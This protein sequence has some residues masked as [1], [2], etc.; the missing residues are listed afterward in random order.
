MTAPLWVTDLAAAFWEAANGPEPFPRALLEPVGRSGFNLTVEALTGLSLRKVEQWVATLGMPLP[1][2][3][4]DRPL[5]ACLVARSGGGFIFLEAADSAEERTFSLAHE[6]AHFLRDYWQRRRRAVAVFGDAILGVF[7]GHRPARAEERLHALLRGVP[8]GLHVHLMT[9]DH[10][11]SPTAVARA[12]D[13][14][15]RLAWEL[16]A[17]EADV[18]R[19]L[20][21]RPRAG[22]A[23]ALLQ[24]TFGL[25]LPAAVDYAAELFPPAPPPD[26]LAARLKKAWTARRTGAGSAEQRLGGSGDEQRR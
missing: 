11:R 22:A 7:D 17:P 24:R 5:R 14:A 18:R 25:P 2:G 6:L 8:V 26:P 9:R 20:P 13:A 16:L 10:G 1:C 3:E 23:V 21:R 15:D 12:E 19:R 4:P